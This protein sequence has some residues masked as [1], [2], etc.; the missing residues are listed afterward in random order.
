MPSLSRCNWREVLPVSLAMAVMVPVGTMVLLYVDPV[1]L[2]WVIAV[3][4]IT[5]LAVLASGWRYQGRPA[6]PASLGVG[7]IAGIGSGAVQ[8]AGPA[9]I[10][11]W[12]GGPSPA[13]IVR[14][15][16]MVFFLLSG[17]AS[18]VAYLTQGLFTADALALAI[19]LGV[20]FLAAMSI[21]ALLFR[22]ASETSYRSVAYALIAVAAVLSLPVFD[23]LLVVTAAA[24]IRSAL[25]FSPCGRRCRAAPAARR[26][27]GSSCK[28]AP[29]PGFAPAGPQPPSPARER[30]AVAQEERVCLRIQED[31]ALM[32]ATSASDTSK[33]A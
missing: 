4:V 13:A 6:L 9:V 33:L 18:G 29:A 30:A 1:V 26:M 31:Y 27:R 19:L 20:P 16:L 8:I 24:A 23:R 22:G 17:I 10:I 12:L 2:R 7:A 14:A 3:L 25:S 32:R 11:Y 5:L 15:N 28:E 21:G